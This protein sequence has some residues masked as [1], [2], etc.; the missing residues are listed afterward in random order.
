[1]ITIRYPANA[2]RHRPVLARAI[3]AKDVTNSN[4]QPSLDYLK[5]VGGG[6]LNVEHFRSECGL[7]VVVSQEEIEKAV[8]A[9]IQEKK[10]ELLEK[11]YFC[12]PHNM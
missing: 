2:I 11:R 3:A 8:S 1:M 7:G 5:K 12:L 10:E 9:L 4:L 6:E